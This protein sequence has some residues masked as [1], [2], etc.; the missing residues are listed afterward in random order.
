MSYGLR[1]TKIDDNAKS[2]A[3]IAEPLVRWMAQP[4]VVTKESPNMQQM[5]YGLRAVKTD[6]DA[7]G[8][9][10]QVSTCNEWATVRGLRS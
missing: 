3:R 2:R 1:A 4:N 8:C 7:K 9:A 6:G 5:G 10:G